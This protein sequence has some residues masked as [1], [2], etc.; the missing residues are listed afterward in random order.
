MKIHKVINNNIVIV[1]D[2]K[3]RERILM[4]R[5]IVFL[6][7]QHGSQRNLGAAG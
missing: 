4:G 5:G 2:K 1:I 3:N 7:Q 6:L